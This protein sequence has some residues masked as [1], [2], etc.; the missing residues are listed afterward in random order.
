MLIKFENKRQTAAILNSEQIALD[1]IDSDPADY[2]LFVGDKPCDVIEAKIEQN[3][4]KLISV[5]EQTAEYAASILKCAERL[6]QAILQPAFF[7]ETNS[8]A[9]PP[10]NTVT[11]NW[12]KAAEPTAK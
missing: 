11:Q 9:L 1:Q 10:L 7:G 5:E 6:C 8:D 3:G 2:I 4:R 12:L